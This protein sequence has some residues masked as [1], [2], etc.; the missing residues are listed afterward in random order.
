MFDT[1]TSR[2]G[3]IIVVLGVDVQPLVSVMI[4]L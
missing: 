3:S 2:G 1:A 4:A